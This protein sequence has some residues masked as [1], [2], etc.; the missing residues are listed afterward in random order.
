M[1]GRRQQK[2]GS[3]PN[4][5]RHCH[6]LFVFGAGF[7]PAE[8]AGVLLDQFQEDLG[9]GFEFSVARPVV[10]KARRWPLDDKE[11]FRGIILDAVKEYFFVLGMDYEE[12][13][14][15]IR[16]YQDDENRSYAVV[17]YFSKS[18]IDDSADAAALADTKEQPAL[19]DTATKT[20]RKKRK[21][22]DQDASTD[23][24]P[25]AWKPALEAAQRA[26]LAAWTRIRQVPPKWLAVGTVALVGVV[27]LIV[28]GPKAWDALSDSIADMQAQPDT[29]PEPD[30]GD[31]GSNST[32]VKTDNKKLPAPKFTLGTV[33]VYTPEPG[34]FVAIDGEPVRDADGKLIPTPCAV[35]T[36]TGTHRVT[37]FREGFVDATRLLNVTLDGEGTFDP[38]ADEQKVGSELLNAPHLSAAVGQPIAM[39][40]INSG[41][42]ERDPFVTPDGLTLWFSGDRAEGRGIYKATRVSPYHDFEEP[43]IVIRSADLPA[44]PSVS[45]DGLLLAY[46]IPDKGRLMYLNRANAK[47]DFGDKKVLRQSD[48]ENV[49]WPSAQVLADGNRIYW[50]EIEGDDMKTFS[51]SRKD[52]VQKFD[53]LLRVSMPGAHP[54][55]SADGLRQYEFDGKKLT[56]HRRAN[57]QSKF[58]DGGHVIA[59][60]ELP[61]FELSDDHRQFFVSAD[62]QWLYYCDNPG[63]SGD[64]FMVR[65]SDGPQWGVKPSAKTI[66]PKGQN[67]AKT[68]ESDPDTKMENKP[69]MK[70]EP[71]PVDPRTLPLPYAAH[72]K[73]YVA[74]LADRKYDAAEALLQTAKD[75]A[76]IAPFKQQ[77]DWDEAELVSLRL[78]WSEL[79]EHLG[80]MKEGDTIRL[81]GN[82]VS[83]LSF[84]DG[85]ITAKAGISNLKKPL[86]ELPPADLSALFDAIHKEPTP[87]EQLRM[88]TF[89]MYDKQGTE[90]VL[91]FR[92]DKAGQLGSDL[93]DHRARRRLLLAKAEFARRNYGN[94]VAFMKEVRDLAG[95]RSD[96]IKEVDEMQALLFTLVK[97]EPRG[98]RK[99][100][101][102]NG[103]YRATME[104]QENSILISSEEFEN[105]ELTLEWQT[106]TAAQAQGGVYFNYP[107]K[108][109]LYEKSYKLHVAND[110]GFKPDIYSSGSLFAI[111][112]PTVNAVN[113]PGEWNTLKIR[114]QGGEVVAIIN[115][116]EV[117]KAGLNDPKVPN[118]GHVCLDG[119][120][121]GITYRKV[122]LTELPAK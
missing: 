52:Q 106:E 93:L 110:F 16:D 56:R 55:L 77:L 53:K 60:L 119:G 69:E 30:D 20:P 11:A 75:N 73:E 39:K 103:T 67:I 74:Q 21:K 31:D 91:K 29:K 107:G 105:F 59:E 25:P 122:L 120:I 48:K 72:L 121:G 108:G 36:E 71:K 4:K 10:R 84:D 6:T 94:G 15:L 116:K 22:S 86:L 51:M 18:T 98:K 87:D 8:F 79:T 70:P 109:D 5:V 64:L 95:G 100:V 54:C 114:V 45:S 66:S 47:M 63:E 117:Q 82:N 101:I 12:T 34:F 24:G 23:D 88:A 27:V 62:E 68:D 46:A 81:S 35:Q 49:T 14:L 50:V 90:K 85:V 96:L 76:E 2:S 113:K 43:A 37:V 40:N 102:E 99:W 41:R 112:Q 65:L 61:D 80:K 111:T 1:S 83:F 118:K 19:V 92:S 57:L 58:T 38:E 89:L 97:W 33:R 28:A 78:L 7:E 26:G 9:E 32:T 44:A 13:R 42:A 104:R 17:G 115:G 3:S